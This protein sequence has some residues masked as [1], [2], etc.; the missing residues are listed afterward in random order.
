MTIERRT[1]NA[2]KPLKSAANHTNAEY[3]NRPGNLKF[4]KSATFLPGTHHDDG[5]K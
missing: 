4:S 2:T 3:L 5:T 1:L